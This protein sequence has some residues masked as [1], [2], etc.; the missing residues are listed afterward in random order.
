MSFQWLTK[1][2]K[3]N[4]V[5]T[6]YAKVHFDNISLVLNVASIPFLNQA[7]TWFLKIDPVQIIG[8]CVCVCVSVPEAINN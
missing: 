6:N 5:S 7:R 2:G 3:I 4:H 1:P 8:M